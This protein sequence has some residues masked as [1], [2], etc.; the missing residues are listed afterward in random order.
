MKQL[1]AKS[2][3]VLQSCPPPLQ[4]HKERWRNSGDH[5]SPKYIEE[6]PCVKEKEGEEEDEEEERVGGGG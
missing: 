5:N 2:R 4:L 6:R 3:G 1:N